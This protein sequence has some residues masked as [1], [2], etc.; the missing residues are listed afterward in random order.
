[1]AL[2][3]TIFWKPTS[4]GFNNSQMSQYKRQY[5][6]NYAVRLD[7][8]EALCEETI[9]N[10][11]QFW[12]SYLE[13]SSII[14]EGSLDP[15]MK[16]N[17]KFYKTEFFSNVKLSYS[18]NLLAR[19]PIEGPALIALTEDKLIRREW[20]KQEIVQAVGA[21][22][23]KL[24]EAGVLEGDT[25]AALVPNSPEAVIAMMAVTGLGAIWS[26]C[27]PDFGVQGVLD[28]FS[29]IAPKF[30]FFADEVIY[31]GKRFSLKEKNYEVFS[32]LPTVKA[33]HTF[34]HLDNDLWKSLGV[35]GFDSNSISSLH[36]QRF[37]FRHP[38]FVM[39]SSGTTGQ[40]KC[41]VHS[42]G[43]TLLQHQKELQLHCDL[44]VGDKILY[45]TTCG[46]MMWNW[47][48]SAL[49]TG[50]IVYCYDG[51]PAAPSADSLWEIVEREELNVF[52]TSAKFIGS[53]RNQNLN[54]SSKFSF[55]KLRLVL[56]TGSPLLP[57]DFDYFYSSSLDSMHRIQLAS[58]CG[59]TD[60]I[61]CF[62]LGNPM[63]PVRRGEIQGRGLGMNVQA[64]SSSGI[65]L[66]ESQGELVCVTPFPSMPLEFWNDPDNLLFEKSYFS[67][68]PNI[69][70]HGDYVTMTNEGGIIVYGRSDA[71][72]NPSGV[73]IGTAEI[74]RQVETHPLIADSLAVGRKTSDDEEVILFVKFK[75]PKQILD[76]T[77]KKEIRLRIRQGASPRHV[78]SEIYVVDEI[79]YTVSGKKV[80]IAIKK[81]LHG[82]DPGNKE[83]LMNPESL[84][85]YE[86]FPKGFV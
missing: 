25:V 24:Q 18:E 23:K 31:G 48:T 9:K 82:Q 76:D 66:R 70:H 86:N 64:W 74:Y 39:F 27:S 78:P 22:Q 53:C 32:K 7:D 54:L 15:A 52:G 3:N 17:S 46:W 71:T 1:M 6:L 51:S 41:I 79:P 84:K 42:N 59:G 65:P 58:I 34:R 26:S 77:I 21:L 49:S 37:A 12:K 14:F 57:E 29:Q 81:I 20:S 72:L 35:D 13:F 5:E 73:R 11:S 62:M 60:I 56:S 2:E 45:Y 80:E 44:K 68:F 19:M 10:P 4:V 40:P 38:L 33:S 75:N 85:L 67:V 36:I 30:I 43:G 8:Y 63:K 61:S 47:V 69:W 50:A 55:S 16:I 28:R 83:A